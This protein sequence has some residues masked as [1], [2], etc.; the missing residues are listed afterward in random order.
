[1]GIQGFPSPRLV[2]EPRLKNSLPY[3][4][5]IARE[6]GRTDGFMPFSMALA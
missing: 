2:A 5:L 3:D 4:S 1:M 6:K